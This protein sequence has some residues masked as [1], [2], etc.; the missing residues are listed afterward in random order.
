MTLLTLGRGTVAAVFIAPIRV[1]QSVVSPMMVERCRFYPSC[2]HYAIAAIRIH[3][4]I[5]GLWMAAARL[6]RCHPWNPGGVDLVPSQCRNKNHQ[7][8]V[9]IRATQS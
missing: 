6:C 7:N 4:P 8:D 2:S 5:K 3:G 9:D 1:Y